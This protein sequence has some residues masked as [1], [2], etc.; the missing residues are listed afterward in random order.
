MNAQ[1]ATS[2]RFGTALSLLA[3]VLLWALVAHVKAQPDL[4]PGPGH[5]ASVLW[6]ETVRGPLLFH[7]GMTFL[8]V[9]AAFLLAMTL[10]S[11]AGLLLGLSP[12]TDRLAGPWTKIFLNL[13]ALVII[14]LCYI[15]IGL[16]EFAA[17][18][19][20]TLSKTPM[21]IT[22]LREGATRFD[23]AIS[24]M[25][26]VFHFSRLARIRHVYL[27]QLAPYII[28]SARNGLAVIWKIVLVVE[29][30]GR[31][32]GAG[33]QIHLY[34]QLFDIGRVLAYAAAFTALMLV[35][36]GGVIGPLARRS[37]AWRSESSSQQ[38][39]PV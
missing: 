4:L 27:P 33:F 26:K 12:V 28:A 8:R 9:A 34:F 21:V 25:A 20:V 37:A 23:P 24:D 38:P 11:A 16:N 3:F 32:N 1:R 39:S 19:A 35:V 29:F 13:P 14:V 5:V 15:W 2:S 6:S 18:L 22:A 36:D 30:L 7:M 10:G 31:S 17:I